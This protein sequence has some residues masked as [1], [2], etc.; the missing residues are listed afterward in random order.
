MQL[1]D[2]HLHVHAGT[3]VFPEGGVYCINAAEP[4]HWQH[5]ARYAAAH[6]QVR[7]FAGIHPWYAEKAYD[8]WDADLAVLLETCPGLGVGEAGLDKAR[9]LTVPMDQQEA[10][11]CR[12]LE[13]AAVYARPVSLHCVRAYSRLIGILEAMRPVF[14]GCI[15]GLVHRFSGG[16]E[17]LRRLSLLGLCISF[18]PSIAEADPGKQALLRYCAPGKLLL[19]TDSENG[20][21]MDTLRRHYAWTASYL[22]IDVEILARQVMENGTFCTD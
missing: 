5:I 13:L 7:A 18:H 12:Q 21:D 16:L 20:P 1:L 8:G 6:A 9:E 19:E 2:A 15:R 14:G 4:A 11:F 10:V 17:E 3:G 22:G